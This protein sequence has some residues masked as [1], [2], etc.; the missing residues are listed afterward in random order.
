MMIDHHIFR[1]SFFFLEGNFPEIWVKKWWMAYRSN[2]GS[3]LMVFGDMDGVLDDTHL[4]KKQHPWN[5]KTSDFSG[6]KILDFS[7]MNIPY[8]SWAEDSWRINILLWK[9]MD[10]LSLVKKKRTLWWTNILLWL[11][12]WPPFCQKAAVSAPME[13]V[14][15]L[16]YGASRAGFNTPVGW[17]L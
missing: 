3:F 1:V 5:G 2:L 10:D 14:K 13:P 12:S 16:F 8:P 15:W 4:I 6:P 9:D 7:V 11:M 17:W